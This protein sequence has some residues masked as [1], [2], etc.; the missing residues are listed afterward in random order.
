M[1]AS[2]F[3]FIISQMVTLQLSFFHPS[4]DKVIIMLL[5]LQ[6]LRCW[7]LPFNG[8]SYPQSPYRQSAHEGVAQH[9]VWRLL[10]LHH[11]AVIWPCSKVDLTFTPNSV[12]TGGCDC[13][14]LTCPIN[15]ELS[16]AIEERQRQAARRWHI[17]CFFSL[18]LWLCFRTPCSVVWWQ[19]S[20]CLPV[21]RCLLLLLLLSGGRGLLLLLLFYFFV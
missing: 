5:T 2:P 3:G 11:A 15:E 20:R 10:L 19:K 13:S 1:F 6:F 14:A 12:C 17:L 18:K 9:A 8:D 4:S 7:C 16:C 21:V